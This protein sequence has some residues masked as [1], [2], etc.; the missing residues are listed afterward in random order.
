MNAPRRPAR[1]LLTPSFIEELESRQ[2]LSASISGGI[3]TVTGTNKADN[4][5]VRVK[6]SNVVVKQGS[7]TKNFA[8]S[9]VNQLIVNGG[10]GNDKI[11]VSGPVPNVVLN[12]GGGN[13]RILGSGGGDLISGGTGNDFLN[14]RKGDD[15]I[16]GD[17]GRDDIFG[18]AG[19]DTLGGDDEDNIVPNTGGA[20]SDTLSGGPGDDWLLMGQD[21]D[22]DL[23]PLTAGIQA[24]ISDPSG[25]DQLSGGSGNDVVD[26]RGRDA[27]GF[28]DGSNGTITQ[29]DPTDI[30][31]VDDVTGDVN[32]EAD[33]S[34][35]KHAFLILKINGQAITI[36]NGAGQFFGQPVVHTHT[37]PVPLDVRGNLLHFHNTAS[38]GGAS[39]VFT[40]G[41]FFEHWGISFSGKNIGRCR[42]DQKHT[43]TMQV[44]AKGA[45]AFVNNTQFNNYV[46]Q[47]AD[48]ATD[49]QYDQII[50]EYKTA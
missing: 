33:Y 21:T 23:D 42:V 49:Q 40:L 27:D 41:D 11:S 25:N 34:H 14:G 6:G 1:S 16:Y 43:L 8:R 19:N 36:G 20:F 31:P 12:G 4:I 30:I 15:Q 32:S 10:N 47:T 35:H 28:E 3:L 45:G 7:S 29:T 37:A 13:D 9:A 39:R 2:L 48:D 46:I 44:K 22:A 5:Q 24:G 50:I 18:A 26:I 38:S 17:D